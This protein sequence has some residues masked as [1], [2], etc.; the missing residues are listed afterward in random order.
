MSTA[1]TWF[2]GVGC[3]LVVLGAVVFG[4]IAIGLRTPSLP[5]QMILA[6]DLSGPVT[7]VTAEDP[8]AELMG[9]KSLSM[10]DLRVLLSAA[11]E[12]DRVVGMRLRIGDFGA[13]AAQMEELRALIERLGA[14]GKWTAAYADTY[15][16][17]SP[18]NWQ[19]F[20]ASA[21]DEVV[22][23]PAGDL[24][25]V[26]LSVRSPFIRG[27]FDKLGMTPEFPGRGDY[28]TARFM[29]TEKDFTPAQREM[30]DWLVS[31]ILDGMVEGIARG[32]GVEQTA[33]RA[34]IDRGPFVGREAVEAGLV[35][36]MEDWTGFVERLEAKAD[37]R[38]GFVTASS[39]LAQVKKPGS[40]AKI[41]VVTGVG[42]IMRG[43]SRKSFNP[44]FGG[45]VMGS[46]TLA[47][48]FRKVR[49]DD[50]IKAVVFRVDSP[51]GSAVASEVIRQ[52]MVRT[53]A[54]VPVVVSMSNVAASGGYWISCGAQRIVA[55]SMTITGSI[56]VFGGHL[57]TARFWEDKLGITF[58]R[59]DFGANANL[60]GDLED[61]TDPQ[62]AVVD[63]LL[64]RIYDDFLTRVAEAR[65]MSTEDVD[66]V[67]R[68]RVWTGAQA[69][70]RGLVDVIGGFDVAVNEARSLAGID[71]EK[72]IRLVDFPK[73]EPF[74]KQIL[75]RKDHEEA[76]VGEALAT[77]EQWWRTGV[78]PTPGS[79]WMPPVTVN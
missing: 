71:P 1:R 44:L 60:Y 57:N 29:Y 9:E 73:A 30:T 8:L 33:I 25:L 69:L 35:D 32:R 54:K 58:G 38:G 11:A 61:W 43:E 24:N 6:L 67:A 34:A 22:M 53:A 23:S 79:V 47:R 4:L 65:G 13:G 62:R 21:C 5:K 15:G 10:R 39:Y 49:S 17:F 46:D 36:A 64:D 68:G 40:G 48:A 2:L 70:E 77:L 18:G 45:D 59:L 78:P 28:K 3:L 7:E 50:G 56:G 72:P 27:M 12:D 55:D 19:Y 20:M 52:E 26:G 31:A 16:E 74:W 66:A 75:K 76:A 42:A 37:G 41:A 63:R 51:G 14:A